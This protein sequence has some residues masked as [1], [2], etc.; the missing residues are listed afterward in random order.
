MMID[1]I[2]NPLLSPLLSMNPLFAIILIAL[3]VSSLITLVTKYMTDQVLMKKL[4]SDMKELQ[5]KMKEE[6][7]QPDKMM[8][9]QKKLMAKNMTYMKSS[10]KSTFITFLPIILVFSWLNAH[11]AFLPIMP[12]QEFNVE[13]TFEKGSTGNVELT[14]PEEIQILTD[15]SVTIKDNKAEWTLRGQE[16][17]S[18]LQF[19][20]ND[21]YFD[22]EL[23]ITESKEYAPVVKK[24]KDPNVKSVII[25]NEKM[26]PMNLFGWKVGWLGT[27]I[28]FSILFSMGLRKLFKLH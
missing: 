3:L 26:K 18:L 24:F 22:K 11:L 27:Y 10:M 8:K 4:K 21:R 5:A 2:L 20:Y 17:D 7:D 28:I 15:S 19:A 23:L 14:V 16:S 13:M 12:D 1:A 9:T 6:K 25:G